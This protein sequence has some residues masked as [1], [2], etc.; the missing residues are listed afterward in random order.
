MRFVI[1]LLTSLLAV[2][3]AAADR[4]SPSACQADAK[5]FCGGRA[6]GVGATCLSNN[7]DKLTP[8]CRAAVLAGRK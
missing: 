3:P 8:Q 4:S 6:K 7:L 5:K 1:I 2:S